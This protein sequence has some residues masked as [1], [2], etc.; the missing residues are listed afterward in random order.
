MSA[1]AE[2][3]CFMKLLVHEIQCCR[4]AA[5]IAI[6]WRFQ[7]FDNNKTIKQDYWWQPT[8]S[9]HWSVK[10]N[11]NR[12]VVATATVTTY[13]N[14]ITRGSCCNFRNDH[15]SL[16]AP[17]YYVVGA[18]IAMSLLQCMY[19]CMYV[20]GWVSD[21]LGVLSPNTRWIVFTM[22]CQYLSTPMTPTFLVDGPKFSRLIVPS[23]KLSMSAAE[24]FRLPLPPSGIH[25]RK[26]VI[27]TLPQNL[28][29]PALIPGH[30]SVVNNL[31]LPSG[32]S[33]NDD[34]LRPF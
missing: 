24:L 19:V 12:L 18:D 8:A 7:L 15:V 32:P 26:T 21:C 6:S 13:S 33:S 29:V 20:C 28:P 9:K 31:T 10:Q 23:V 14:A 1:I 16:S 34:Y 22:H 3:V 11:V 5:G 25:S 17:T 30:S 2:L 27:S 4:E